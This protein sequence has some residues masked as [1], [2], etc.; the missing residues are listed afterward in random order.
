[1][2]FPNNFQILLFVA[3]LMP[4]F[5]Q[6][7]T[8]Y[9]EGKAYNSFLD[10]TG[11]WSFKKDPTN[12]GETN[13]WFQI[14]FDRSDWTVVQ[15]PGVWDEP[16]GAV[17]T[18][19]YIGTAWYHKT[20]AIP[21]DWNQRIKIFS[22]GAQLTAR[23]WLNGQFIGQ[24]QGGYTP[25]ELDVTGIAAVGAA[26]ELTIRVDNTTSDQ[27]IPSLRRA[28]QIYGGLTR[29]L[30]MLHQP[31]VRA[32]NIATSTTLQNND[33]AELNVRFE[34]QNDAGNPF[35]RPVSITLYELQGTQQ[36]QIRRNLVIASTPAGDKQ[37]LNV[38]INLPNAK[39]WSPDSPQLYKIKIEWD[40][41]GTQQNE[42][43]I[44][45]RELRWDGPDFLLNGQPIWMQGFGWHEQLMGHG[46]VLPPG[47][48]KQQLLRMKNQ[49][50]C[51]SIRP[52]HY[53]MHPEFYQLCNEL[54]FLVTAEIPAWQIPTL[55]LDSQLTWQA[56]LEPQLR[57]MAVSLRNHPCVAFWG[58]SNE[59]LR[60]YTYFNCAR[61]LLKALDNSRPVAPVIDSD[62]DQDSWTNSDIGARNQHYGWYHSNSVYDLNSRLQ[63]TLDNSSGRPV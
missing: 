18:D 36:I 60:A 2:N 37:N 48:R 55:T 27:T 23:V 33:V 49:F 17:G 38:K 57:E 47:H 19:T 62:Y 25:F 6:A 32:Q 34:I 45:I 56:W 20:I 10:L 8:D 7:N 42:T 9:F 11:S 35:N 3:I 24:H 53:P 14:G 51:N 26:N 61:D 43:T 4:S 12:T 28:W 16:S 5:V 21:A 15:V 29:E 44:G 58:V 63:N 31:L 1:M 40:W 50:N 46:S 59:S 52:G 30:Y 41:F 54:G 13:S 39:L 22:L